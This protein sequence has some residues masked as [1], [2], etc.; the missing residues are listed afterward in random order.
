MYYQSRD[1]DTIRKLSAEV[2]RLRIHCNQPRLKLSQTI[3]EM[4]Q[5][6][7]QNM[8]YDHLIH[9]DKENPFKP[10]KMCTIL[11]NSAFFVQS[12]IKVLK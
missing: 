7:E 11:W 1:S 5:Y 10:K 4:I 9:P 6:C 2:E 8:A 12:E 3:R